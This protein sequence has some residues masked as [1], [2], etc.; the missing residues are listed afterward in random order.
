MVSGMIDQVA[1]PGEHLRAEFA[2]V[3]DRLHAEFDDRAGSAL[4][5]QIF[6]DI[7]SRFRNAK[8]LTFLPVLVERD[9]RRALKELAPTALPTAS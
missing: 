8:V 7:A 9:A 4:V 2:R 6:T 3:A 5:D 1:E